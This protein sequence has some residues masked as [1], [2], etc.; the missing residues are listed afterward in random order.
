MH[1]G[2]EINQLTFSHNETENMTL[3]DDKKACMNGLPHRSDMFVP[4][5][6]LVPDIKYQKHFMSVSF[7]QISGLA[8]K[9]LQA[10]YVTKKETLAEF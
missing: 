3:I 5:T 2:K 6:V 9:L 7:L 10:S 8:C 4:L 1:A